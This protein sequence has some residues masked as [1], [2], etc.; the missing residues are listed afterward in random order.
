MNCAGMSNGWG[1][2]AFEI[3]E[4]KESADMGHNVMVFERSVSLTEAERGQGE[5]RGL[6]CWGDGLYVG[7]T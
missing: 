4:A 2:K 7:S 5:Q 6:D 1:G 3:D